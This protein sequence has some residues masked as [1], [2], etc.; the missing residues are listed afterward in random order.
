[1]RAGVL[2]SL[3]PETDRSKLDEG[4]I[5]GGELVVASGNTPALLDLVEEPLDKAARPVEIG[6]EADGVLANR[7]RAMALNQDSTA[8]VAIGTDSIYVRG[9]VY[10]GGWRWSAPGDPN[11]IHWAVDATWTP[12][13]IQTL[14]SM[15]ATWAAVSSIT[16]QQVTNPN[17]A[18]IVL[19]QTDLQDIGR[20]GF[21]GIPG[22]ATGQV[23]TYFA[24]TNSS[25]LAGPA[26]LK[27]PP[28]PRGASA[29][30]VRIRRPGRGRRVCVRRQVLNAVRARKV[31]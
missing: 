25:R 26:V 18:E 14:T 21:S 15:F 31:A 5:I 9:L 7:R 13:Q 27:A 23:H 24:A 2:A 10:E 11:V 28:P 20:P 22:P 30:R 1:M 19:H 12:L 6:T 4:E 8:R 3:Y 17:D 16:F 29:C